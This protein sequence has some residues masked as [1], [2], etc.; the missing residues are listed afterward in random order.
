M[1]FEHHAI[2]PTCEYLE[3]RGIWRSLIWMWTGERSGIYSVCLDRLE[4]SRSS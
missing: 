4:G 2:L 3:K 1:R